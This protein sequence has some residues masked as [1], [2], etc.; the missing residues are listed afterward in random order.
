MEHKV[1]NCSKDER[2]SLYVAPALCRYGEV[3][4]LTAGGTKPGNENSGNL[5]GNTPKP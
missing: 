3:T 4:K 2:P 1:E 5:Q